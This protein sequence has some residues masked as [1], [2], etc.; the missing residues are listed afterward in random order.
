MTS[1]HNELQNQV[2]S[3]IDE[4]IND[5]SEKYQKL[6]DILQWDKYVN[7]SNDL[8]PE[9][10]KLYNPAIEFYIEN[11]G[12]NDSGWKS[13]SNID[14]PIIYPEYIPSDE[15]ITYLCKQKEIL[16]IG[17]G[18][19]YWSHIINENGGNSKPT[20]LY[21]QHE[22]YDE[23]IDSYPVTLC[24]R[25]DYP[26]FIWSFVDKNDHSIVS[27]YPDKDILLCHPEG[28]TWTEELLKL[29]RT[30]QKLILIADWYPS[31]NATPFFFKE[32]IDNWTLE[33]QLPVYSVESNHAQM[34]EFVKNK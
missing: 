22:K 32:L 16:E 6:K 11:I 24:A 9:K 18:S 29:M 28:L 25:E 5:S 27:D 4:D 3:L 30:G 26:E 10:S 33:K 15:V 21:P 14:I 34:Y 23:N 8:N 17:A 20:D 19:G 12:W 7:K 1:L 2:N 13:F 31:A